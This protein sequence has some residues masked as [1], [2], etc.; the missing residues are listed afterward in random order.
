LL[1][2]ATNPPQIPLL[3]VTT[4]NVHRCRNRK[5]YWIRWRDWLRWTRTNYV[6]LCGLMV[7][8][9]SKHGKG[10]RGVGPILKR[11]KR[12]SSESLGYKFTDFS[13]HGFLEIH[14][15]GQWQCFSRGDIPCHTFVMGVGLIDEIVV[16]H[17]YHTSLN[18]CLNIVTPF[19]CVYY[20]HSNVSKM[21]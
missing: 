1:S 4:C 16:H 13:E 21:L 20:A 17:A 18:I 9:V 19:M 11:K 5:W 6:L 10:G 3:H 12:R 8:F 2:W 7:F 14:Q 15:V